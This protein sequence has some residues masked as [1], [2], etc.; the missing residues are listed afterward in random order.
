MADQFLA[1]LEQQKDTIASY[2]PSYL[3]TDAERDRFFANARAVIQ[4]YKLAK[5]SPQSL[6][7]CVIDAAKAGLL[8]GGPEKHCAV[9]PFDTKGG[10]LAAILIVQWQGKSFLWHRA[11]AIT[12]LKAQV[13]YQGDKFELIEG[14]EDRIVHQPDLTADHTPD[15]LNDL[16]HIVGAYAIA[17]LPNG[18]R[19]HRFVSRAH[20]RRTMESVKKKNNG[21][22]GFG[23]SDWLPEMCMKTAIHRL[24]GLI[25]PR[26]KMDD[27]QREAWTLTE[28]L[29]IREA[30][31]DE[32]DD[33]P[34]AKEPRQVKAEVV[35]SDQFA[36]KPPK[37]DRS[38]TDEE[39]D[40]IFDQGISY[41][42]KRSQIVAF[43]KQWS[44]GKMSDFGELKYSQ[45]A[46]F[47]QKLQEAAS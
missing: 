18:D 24:T 47:T 41:G 22:L 25:Q 45:L 27:E 26:P 4:D 44:D 30:G 43:L 13:V 28:N 10:G 34:T 16:N 8:I 2:L 11:G 9:V 36:N 39:V 7:N 6:L 17:W 19:L 21:K 14:D 5:C 42:M 12:K 38:I 20:I 1:L 31:I 33:I 15:W 29:D 23:W 32:P 37:E 46:E 35:P 40:S 3:R